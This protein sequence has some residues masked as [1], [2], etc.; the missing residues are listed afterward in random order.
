MG[1][2]NQHQFQVHTYIAGKFNVGWNGS[3]EWV[4]NVVLREQKEN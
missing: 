4:F 2:V 3:A 1:G